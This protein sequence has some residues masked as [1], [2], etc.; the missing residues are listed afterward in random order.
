MFDN[1]STLISEFKKV[2]P[3]TKIAIVVIPPPAASQDAFGENYNCGQPCTR[4]QYR[5]KQHYAVERMIAEFANREKENLFL[6]P[7]FVNLDCVNNYPVSE[8]QVNARNPKKIFRQSN[9]LHPALEGYYQIADSFY[10]WFK[11]EFNRQNRQ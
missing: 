4:N 8:E 5:K 2:G 7:V 10:A 3:E 11:Y 1:A 6:I 9:A